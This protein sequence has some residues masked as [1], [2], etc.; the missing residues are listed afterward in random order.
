MTMDISKAIIQG[1]LMTTGLRAKGNKK[2]TA[3]F[4]L[5]TEGKTTLVTPTAQVIV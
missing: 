3:D 4:T 1:Q 5:A 2:Q